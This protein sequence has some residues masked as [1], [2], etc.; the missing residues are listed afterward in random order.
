MTT[1]TIDKRLRERRSLGSWCP[2]HRLPL[3]TSTS[4]SALVKG[5]FN[6]KS[7]WI[8]YNCFQLWASFWTEFQWSAKACLESGRLQTH[9]IIAYLRMRQLR[10]IIRDT[11][12]F[13][14]STHSVAI[15]GTFTSLCSP[16]FHGIW[17]FYYSRIMPTA[18]ES[19]VQ[20]YESRIMPGCT[21]Q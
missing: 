18:D 1:R 10:V 5:S 7:F 15:R 6:L 14:C 12:S 21:L 2:L 3:S 9:L 13:D 19:V 4:V 16:L 11:I 17:G 8:E 20:E